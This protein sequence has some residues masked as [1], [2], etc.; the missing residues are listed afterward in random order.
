[1]FTVPKNYLMSPYCAP[2]ELLKEFPQ[3][4]I[5]TIHLD[6]CLD[7]CVEFSKKLKRLGVNIKLDIVDGLV[8]GF[9]NFAQV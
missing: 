7:D 1:M 2:D 8:H 6:P 9:L 5:I 3:T 4:N